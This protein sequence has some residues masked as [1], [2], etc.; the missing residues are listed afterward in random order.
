MVK[1]DSGLEALSTARLTDIVELACRAPSIHNSQPWRWVFDGKTLHLFADDSR[2]RRDDMGVKRAIILSCGVVLDHLQV[3]AAASGWSTVVQRTTD[4]HS[5]EHLASITFALAESVGEHERALA[6]AIRT[7]RTD[8]LAYAAPEP[9]VVLD[10]LIRS[11]V[12]GTVVVFDTID[13]SGRPALADASRRSEAT[14]VDDDSYQLELEWWAECSGPEDGIPFTSLTSYKEAD[15][16]DVAR[17]YPLHGTDNRRPQ[18]DRDHSKILVL[19]T[20]DDSTENILRCGEVLSRVLLECTAAGFATCTLT[21]MI[22]LH[23][24]REMVRTITGRH[25]EPQALI[26]VGRAPRTVP[27]PDPTPRRRIRDVLQIR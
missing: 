9:W 26:R 12:N 18:I 25:A 17:A 20:Y 22:E 3:A 14:R 10:H 19:S 7:R 6:D 27:E 11:V 2:L 5:H 13:D 24:S 8:R 16:V 23:A 1:P 21:H 4:A 15:R